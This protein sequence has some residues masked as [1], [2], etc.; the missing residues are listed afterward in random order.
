MPMCLKSKDKGSQNK[1]HR[2]IDTIDDYVN[3]IPMCLKSKDRE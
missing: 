2:N 1:P 3:Y